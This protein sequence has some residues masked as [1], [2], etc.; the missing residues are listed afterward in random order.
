MFT[1]ASAAATNVL[2]ADDAAVSGTTLSSAMSDFAAADIN[3]GHVAVFDGDALEVL[4]RLS[5]TTLDV[6]RPRAWNMGDA[7]KIAPEQASDK[8][9]K[10]H[11]FARLIERTQHELLQSLGITSDDDDSAGMAMPAI[12]AVINQ[13]TLKRLLAMRTLERAFA[14]AAALDPDD[15]SLLARAALYREA[16]RSAA[17][18]AVLQI[19]AAGDDV[20]DQLLSLAT[21]TL[22]RV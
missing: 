18:S 8:S 6:S 20:P 3:A 7:A 22:W 12:E 5:E 19:D 14:A 15:L 2:T 4:S 10:I 17:A 9:L 1:S 11:T 21:A 16:F 13:T